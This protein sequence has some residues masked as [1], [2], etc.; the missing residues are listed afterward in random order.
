MMKNCVVLAVAGVSSGALGQTASLNIVAS[1][2]VVDSSVTTSITLAVY[3]DVDWGTHIT[4]AAFRVDAVGGVGVIDQM[5]LLEIPL[6]GVVGFGDSGDGGDGNHR[7]IQMGQIVWVPHV[8]PNGMSALGNG[9]VLLGNF[10][11]TLFAGSFGE[12][13]WTLNG[14]VPQYGLEVFDANADPE[15]VP[16]QFRS[17]SSPST[18]SATVHVIPSP[19]SVALLGLCGLIGGRRRR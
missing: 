18:G 12:V 16:S 14:G 17:F 11:A 9:P 13:T 3:G 8:L 1:Q 15:D 2:T 5:S 19:S 6:W 7:G 10:E 4:H